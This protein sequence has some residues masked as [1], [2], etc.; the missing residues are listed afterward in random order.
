M[1]KLPPD[2]ID[3]IVK[4]IFLS[5]PSFGRYSARGEDLLDIMLVEAKA[6]VKSELA[7]GDELSPRTKTQRYLSLAAFLATEKRVARPTSLVQFYCQNFSTKE[8]LA[9]CTEAMRVFIIENFANALS[10][11][12]ENAPK[13]V[14]PSA[15]EVVRLRNQVVDVCPILFSVSA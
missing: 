5:L 11:L 1:F 13:M 6:S 2:D 4:D 9:Q 14:T 15:E 7:A 10:S 12:Q 3:V 8:A